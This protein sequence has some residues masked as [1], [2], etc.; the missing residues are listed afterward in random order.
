M[1]DNYNSGIQLTIV[2]K[3]NYKIIIFITDLWEQFLVKSSELKLKKP[4][5]QR[6]KKISKKLLQGNSEGHTFS[7]VREKYKIT[8]YELL[9]VT[10]SSLNNRFQKNVINH[11]CELEKFI[12]GKEKLVTYVS[13][14]YG[15]DFDQEKLQ[16]HRDMF[17]DIV[18]SRKI[19]IN[20]THDAI[21][22]FKSDN[23]FG[24]IEQ[25]ANSLINSSKIRQNTFFLLY[26]CENLNQ[27]INIIKNKIYLKCV[28]INI[29]Q[30]FRWK[31]S[32]WGRGPE[33]GE[34]PE[35]SPPYFLDKVIILFI[36]HLFRKLPG[37]T[38]NDVIDLFTLVRIVFYFSNLAFTKCQVHL[39]HL[40]LFSTSCMNFASRYTGILALGDRNPI[41]FHGGKNFSETICQ[42]DYGEPENVIRRKIA[43]IISLCPWRESCR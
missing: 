38:N 23:S 10:L 42:R 13:S 37:Y 3:K 28:N 22:V 5:E 19:S 11:L 41:H 35:K 18:K 6:I 2:D 30:R 16:L 34:M 12:I 24:D 7:S 31:I 25:I 1:V 40:Y 33:C 26:F 39:C 36:E 9:D 15:I 29:K 8:F 20:S 32:G 43:I 17:L 27:T 14:F 21:D 4:N